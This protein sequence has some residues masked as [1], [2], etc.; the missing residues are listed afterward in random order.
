MEIGS[1][2]RSLQYSVNS[3]L[4]ESLFRGIANYEYLKEN[5]PG[6][7]M[8]ESGN[9]WIPDLPDQRERYMYHVSILCDVPQEVIRDGAE[10]L[11]EALKANHYIRHEA[12]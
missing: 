4:R 10:V 7:R 6:L 8:D 2:I 1:V 11:I 9:L 12:D 5:V 3:Y